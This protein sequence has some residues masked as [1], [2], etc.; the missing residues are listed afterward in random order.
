MELVPFSCINFNFFE[1]KLFCIFNYNLNLIIMKKLFYLTL[2]IIVSAC[3]SVKVTDTWSNTDVSKLI[4][5]KIVVIA[6]TSDETIRIR[7]E[8]DMVSSLNT[9][10]FEAVSSYV[11]MS[12]I[13]P[14]KKVNEYDT[15]EVKDKLISKGYNLVMM[16]VLK[17]KEN[18][19]KT[20]TDYNG[21]SG[22][23]FY[24]GGFYRGFGAYYGSMYNYGSAYSTTEVA[25]K[26]IVE[27]VIYDLSKPKGKSLLSVV[28]TT[29]DDPSSLSKT[30]ED[31]GNK[32][33]K[34]LLPRK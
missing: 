13:D 1:P 9:A 12:S 30:A 10:G 17:D 22:P 33:V 21:V 15:Q 16:L 5:E 23:G 4:G 25:K 2:I 29:I 34:S 6:K 14:E 11:S 32:V 27:S 19:L 8:K 31:F 3:S 24:G 7:V 20:N 28:T 26:Y 18:Y